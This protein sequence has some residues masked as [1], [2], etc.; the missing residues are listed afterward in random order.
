MLA[1]TFLYVLA[2]MSL[3]ASGLL[4]WIRS[5]RPGGW[6]W[7]PFLF[8]QASLFFFLFSFSIQELYWSFGHRVAPFFAFI[9]VEGVIVSV[10]GI[11]GIS[12]GAPKRFAVVLIYGIAVCAVAFSFILWI[13]GI[14]FLAPWVMLFQFGALGHL[15]VEGWMRRKACL[16][17][18]LGRI[19]ADAL[20]IGIPSLPFLIIDPLGSSLGWDLPELLVGNYSLPFYFLAL[21]TSTA[22]RIGS[23]L[24]R[25][26]LES[27]PDASVNWEDL[28]LSRRECEV[29]A[30]LQKGKSAKEIARQLGVSPKTVENHSYRI[31]QKLG[32]ST[33]FEFLSR[34][35]RVH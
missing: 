9:G 17:P 27:P 1:K 28:G 21:N 2:L 24:S 8:M 12:F 29:A 13:S 5:R 33:R 14:T 4:V 6:V 34:F 19:L 18:V 22:F 20:V 25:K 30:L 26:E 35:G 31:F 7:L 11:L 23:W 10:Y 16:D 32:V 15:I 3:S